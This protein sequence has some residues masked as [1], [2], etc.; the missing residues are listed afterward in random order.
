MGL[1]TPLYL[2]GL[3]ALSLPIVFHLLR[4]SIRK[5]LPFSSL[6]FL[7]QNPPRLTRRSRIENWW[8]LL[9]RAAILTLLVFAFTRPLFRTQQTTQSTMATGRDVVYLVDQSASMQ[10]GVLWQQAIE[11]LRKLSDNSTDR[12]RQSLF[13]YDQ[14]AKVV[15][16]GQTSIDEIPPAEAIRLW[17]SESQPG[18][19]IDDLPSSMQACLDWIT[20]GTSETES[21]D[22]LESRP[23]QIHII[24]DFQ[25]PA[26]NAWNQ[27][28]WPQGATVAMH[29]ITREPT[30]NASLMLL[31]PSEEYQWD[32]NQVSVR[33]T[34][35][36]TSK[37]TVL[38]LSDD[39]GR[40]LEEILLPAGQSRVLSIEPEADPTQPWRLD[41]GGD[42][43][44]F[45][46]QLFLP[47]VASQ[48]VSVAVTGNLG[49]SGET[50]SWM[51]E[52][53]CQSLKYQ[54][55]NWQEVDRLEGIDLNP[56]HALFVLRPLATDELVC[57]RTFLTQGGRVIVALT[58]SIAPGTE[59]AWQDTLCQLGQWT[60]CKVSEATV[61]DFSLVSS[62]DT[63]RPPLD[64][65]RSSTFRDFTSIY[66]WHHRICEIQDTAT[67]ILASF[68]DGAPFLIQKAI[69]SG[70]LFVFTGGWT[71]Q[72][73]QLGQNS[74]FATLMIQISGLR[75]L[76]PPIDFIEIG[77][78]L[79]LEEPTTQTVAQLFDEQGL[80]LATS[81][82]QSSY[83]I[84]QPGL[85]RIR[86]DERDSF[87][88]AQIPSEEREDARTE[89]KDLEGMGIPGG[90]DEQLSKMEKREE[91]LKDEQLESQQQAWRWLLVGVIVLVIGET[92]AS[93]WMSRGRIS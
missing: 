9:L 12:D 62:I 76:R 68:D 17:S 53:A 81:A 34:N 16:D 5:E 10:R 64:L 32:A 23:I 20:T 22:R 21:S 84:D 47:P 79:V 38:T 91:R 26:S 77:E 75:Q 41:L 28:Q 90:D 78:S 55:V 88:I 19:N 31:Q 35:N 61:K 65:F 85:Y 18:W 49:D 46:N 67:K 60:E 82:D 73:S 92:F 40:K 42:Q 6:I 89:P 25:S 3:A 74:R 44:S 93:G 24:S 66:F 45:D 27:I 15:V 58:E 86:R 2:I 4:K 29:H 43:E 37:S 71:P 54:K 33:L 1:L 59:T 8:L 87:V 83:L 39:A 48:S 30:D 52:Q 51:L 69:D 7:R 72:Q 57:V 13:V 36:R 70:E 56:F 63:T 11:Q 14:T 50:S 80:E